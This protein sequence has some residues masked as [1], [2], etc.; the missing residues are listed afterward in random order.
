MRPTTALSFSNA[1]VVAGLFRSTEPFWI[2]V[3]TAAGKASA[4]TL[5]PTDKAVVGSTAV[6]I[7]SC[8]RSVSVHCVSSPKVSKRKTCLPC[9]TR[10][11]CS[12]AE[13]AE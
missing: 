7:T 3:T 5:R 10:A 12:T 2:P 9:A 11:A 8:M 6:R 1:T 4:S 13:L